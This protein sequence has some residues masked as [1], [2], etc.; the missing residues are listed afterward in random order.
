MLLLGVIETWLPNT[1]NSQKTFPLLKLRD[2]SLVHTYVQ[3]SIDLNTPI[4]GSK[5]HAYQAVTDES[6]ALDDAL[7]VFSLLHPHCPA[8]HPAWTVI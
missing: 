6:T 1:S 8:R 3:T 7:A 4:P 2:H 5:S